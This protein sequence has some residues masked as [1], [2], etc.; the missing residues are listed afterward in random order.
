M[1]LQRPGEQPDQEGAQQICEGAHRAVVSVII[2]IIIIII[3]ISIIL[4]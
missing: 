3:I 2:I 1:L 4:L